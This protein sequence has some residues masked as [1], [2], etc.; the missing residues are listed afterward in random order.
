MSLRKRA[1]PVTLVRSPML[2]KRGLN[3]GGP[4]PLA[5]R[6]ASPKGGGLAARLSSP[7]GGRSEG[8]GG[9]RCPSRELER[10]QPC[11]PHG[12]RPLRDLPRGNAGDVVGDVADVVGGGAAA[13]AEDVDDAAP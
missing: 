5:A 6:V 12:V 10:L 11:Q 13:A 4:L 3:G 1:D 9:H 2:T 7:F 8:P